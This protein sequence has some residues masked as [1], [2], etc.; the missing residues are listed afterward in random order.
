MYS[1][2][3]TCSSFDVLVEFIPFIVDVSEQFTSLLV[4]IPT[5]PLFSYF[6]FTFSQCVLVLLSFTRRGKIVHSGHPPLFLCPLCVEQK[7][8]IHTKQQQKPGSLLL[9]GRAGVDAIGVAA[10]MAG[11]RSGDLVRRVSLL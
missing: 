10:M 9:G 8:C 3:G 6:D 4:Q 2:F 5:G 1:D 7:T 11:W